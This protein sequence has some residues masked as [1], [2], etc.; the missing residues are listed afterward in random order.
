MAIKNAD[1]RDDVDEHERR[2]LKK[3]DGVKG[4]TGTDIE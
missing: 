1:D 3:E 4:G 2:K